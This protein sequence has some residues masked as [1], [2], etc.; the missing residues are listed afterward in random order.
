MRSSV[1]QAGARPSSEHQ[2]NEM[3]SAEKGRNGV[4]VVVDGVSLPSGGDSDDGRSAHV[5]L[6][7][8]IIAILLVTAIGF[9]SHWSSGVTGAMKSTLKKVCG[10]YSLKS[11]V[12]VVMGIW[13]IHVLTD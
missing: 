12:C 9:G 7:L 11:E 6:R 1:E 5:P 8:K 10:L 3:V 4:D 2:R 13:R